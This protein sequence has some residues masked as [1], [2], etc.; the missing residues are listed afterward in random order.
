MKTLCTICDKVLTNEQGHRLASANFPAPG[1]RAIKPMT[2][3]ITYA[4]CDGCLSLDLLRQ[5]RIELALLRK[6]PTD[7]RRNMAVDALIRQ[8]ISGLEHSS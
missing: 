6:Y 5:A 3:E 7:Y 8:A 4:Y 2:A 1:S